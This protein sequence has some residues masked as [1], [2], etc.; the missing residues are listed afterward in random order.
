MDV[1]LLLRRV[2]ACVRMHARAYVRVS[3][4]ESVLC[5]YESSE[6]VLCKKS[7]DGWFTH[8]TRSLTDSCTFHPPVCTGDDRSRDNAT[9]TQQETTEQL[10]CTDRLQPLVSKKISSRRKRRGVFGNG[11]FGKGVFVIQ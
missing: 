8:S 3:G 5:E 9:Q 6:R 7:T 2:D 11:V 1:C 4:Y 10:R